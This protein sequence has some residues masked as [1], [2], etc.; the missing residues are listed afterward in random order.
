MGY[1]WLWMGDATTTYVLEY[2]TCVCAGAG[3]ILV[4]L[5]VARISGIFRIRFFCWDK[6]VLWLNG[7][8]SAGLGDIT[9]VKSLCLQFD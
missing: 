2:Y 1:T 5:L 8:F 6:S 7:G 4:W 3:I 9:L